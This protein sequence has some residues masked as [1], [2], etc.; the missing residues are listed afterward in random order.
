[1]TKLKEF[2]HFFREKGIF[3]I[4]HLIILA[5]SILL[6]VLISV[7][8]F[9][10]I[11]FYNQPKFEKWQLWICCVFILDFFIELF[12]SNNKKH[13]LATHI[14]FLIV[15]VPYQALCYRYGLD[16]YMSKELLYVLRY[17]PLIRGGYAMAIVVGWFTSNKAT[18]L[19]FSYII[20][21]LSTVYFA[22]LTFFLFEHGP[23]PLVSTYKDALWWAAMDVTTVGC[24]ISA[25]T[26]VG[27]VLSVLL[28]A[29]G[30][31]M[32]PI[33]TVYVTNLLTKRNQEATY[34]ASLVN[35]YKN[36]EATHP[37]SQKPGTQAVAQSQNSNSSSPAGS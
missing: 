33:F 27:R 30:M 15:S 20:T 1:M 14:I 13:Y 25:V 7:D 18:G 24:N 28:A 2:G 21:L 4:L 22:S 11:N 17:M 5:L 19:F 34:A 32:F 10:N 37:E 35:A 8:T 26:G 9:D 12:L 29:L 6:I 16:Q 23:N 36:F 31:M 3:M